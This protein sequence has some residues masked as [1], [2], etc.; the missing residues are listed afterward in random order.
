M[1]PAGQE[2]GRAGPLPG[3][4]AGGPGTPTSP[5]PCSP[6]PGWRPAGPR[7]K[8]GDRHQRPGHDRLHATGDPPAADQ[9]GPGLRTRPRDA[10]GPGPPGADD[11]STRPGYAT[12]GDAATR[13]PKCRCSINRQGELSRS[14]RHGLTIKPQPQDGSR[15]RQQP[16]RPQISAIARHQRSDLLG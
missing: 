13:S 15:K 8:K 12:T 10:S 4:H 14:S 1:L 11:A 2:R 9:P 5:C 3:P 16:H 7:P 6:W